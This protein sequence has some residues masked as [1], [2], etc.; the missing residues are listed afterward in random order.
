MHRASLAAGA[1]RLLAEQLGHGRLGAHAPG[2]GVAMVAIGGDDVVV[3]P[4][5]SDRSD[6]DRFLAAVLM[7]EAADLV[8]LLVQHLR[9]FLEPADQHHLAQPDEGLSAVH[10]RLRFRLN[11]GHFNLSPE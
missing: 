8:P 2:Q 6:R 1:A 3:F 9:A 5:D 7:K 11:L 4:Q 10:D